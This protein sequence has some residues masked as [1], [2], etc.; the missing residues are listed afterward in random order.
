MIKILRSNLT[1]IRRSKAFLILFALFFASGAGI[2]ALNAM[3]LEQFGEGYFSGTYNLYF[4]MPA[5]LIGGAA[6][7]FCAFFICADYAEGTVR[8]KLIVG[9]TRAQIYFA[10]LISVFIAMSAIFLAYTASA[11]TVGL[12]WFGARTVTGLSKPL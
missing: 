4:F 12:P 3:N 1:R 7:I 8:N 6:A 5:L 2:Y 11:L 9:C 10:N